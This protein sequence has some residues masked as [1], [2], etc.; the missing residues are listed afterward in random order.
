MHPQRQILFPRPGLVISFCEDQV[1][2]QGGYGQWF[3]PSPLDK[4]SIPLTGFITPFGFFY[5]E[6]HGLWFKKCPRYI[7][8]VSTG[9][10]ARHGNILGYVFGG[11]Y[12]CRS[13]L[14]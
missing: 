7:Y 9:I 2:D 5:L 4:E 10:V 3:Q 6:V 1:P 13:D 14:V 12:D 8:L 11:Y